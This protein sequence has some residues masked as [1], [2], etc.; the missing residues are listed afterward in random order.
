ME[1]AVG[2]LE[3][4][5]S[6][7]GLILGPSWAHLGRILGHLRAFGGHLGPILAHLG[8]IFAILITLTLMH[9]T[10]VDITHYTYS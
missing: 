1:L 8:R 6:D 5:L 10:I 7:L 2:Q 4:I 9:L 3:G